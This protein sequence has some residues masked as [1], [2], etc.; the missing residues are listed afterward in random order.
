M[1]TIF[2]ERQGVCLLFAKLWRKGASTM[3]K[4]SKLIMQLE[5]AQ[6]LLEMQIKFE[7]TRL[8]Q[9]FVMQLAVAYQKVSLAEKHGQVKNACS[10]MSSTIE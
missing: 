1:L 4:I 2:S 5:F 10:H 6:Q 9:E 7:Q 3:S 8:T